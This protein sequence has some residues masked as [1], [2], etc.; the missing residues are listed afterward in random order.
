MQ[1]TRVCKKCE[2]ALLGAKEVSVNTGNI[3]AGPAIVLAT[4]SNCPKRYRQPST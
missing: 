1:P 4:G 3:K 2:R